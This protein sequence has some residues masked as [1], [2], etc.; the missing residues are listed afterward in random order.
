LVGSGPNPEAMLAT[1][2]HQLANPHLQRVV[3]KRPADAKAL[4]TPRDWRGQQVS[5]AAGAARFD[6]YLQP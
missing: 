2:L 3:V 5:I 4:T 6:V 1:C